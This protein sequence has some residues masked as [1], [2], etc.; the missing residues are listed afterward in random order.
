MKRMCWFSLVLLLVLAGCAGAGGQGA[1][2][3]PAGMDVRN[4]AYPNEMVASGVAQL[5]DGV[6][7]ED[8]AGSSEKLTV[9]L[10]DPPAYGDIDGDGA[11]DAAVLL[12]AESG[13]SGTFY[14]LSVVV[15]R[16]GKPT[17][18]ATV[19]IDDRPVIE[20]LRIDPSGNVILQATIHK[21]EDAMCCP[22]WQVVQTYHLNDDILDLVT[23]EEK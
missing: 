11:Q 6:Y 9:K 17:P 12:A 22:S 13:G 5:K 7:Q 4:L 20:S 3:A 8:I 21:E 14:Y 19:F 18:A 2:Q 15:T 1:Q 10:V 16:S 23:Q